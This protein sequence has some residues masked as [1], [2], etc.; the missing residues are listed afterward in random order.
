MRIGEISSTDH[1]LFIQESTIVSP[2]QTPDWAGVKPTWEHQKLGWFNEDDAL[3]GAALVLSQPKTQKDPIAYIP[4]GPL[5]RWDPET[6]ESTMSPLLSHLGRTGV[7]AVK[8]DPR[9][10]LRSWSAD[11]IKQ[12]IADPNI[13][14]LRQVPADESYPD[15]IAVEE[16]LAASGWQPDVVEPG[17]YGN[18]QPKFVY[19]LPLKGDSDQVFSGFSTQW[20]RNIRKSEKYGVEVTKGGAELLPEFT[21]LYAETAQ[22]DG[23]TGRPTEYFETMYT[24]MTGTDPERMQVYVARHEDVALAAAIKMTVGKH[25]WYMYGA[26]SSQR[27]EVQASTAVQW[28]MIQDACTRGVETYDFRGITDAVDG[29]HHQGVLQFK[30]G[31][32]GNATEYVGAWTYSFAKAR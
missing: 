31:A 25:A 18:S 8:M 2:L 27:R 12:A 28:Q 23:F 24:S 20:R 32:N 5:V 14:S 17:S 26:S 21:S 6:V 7:A 29:S 11:T 10:A 19:Q 13:T 22:R 3:S 9:L 4:E 16:Y 30:L 15:A 1:E